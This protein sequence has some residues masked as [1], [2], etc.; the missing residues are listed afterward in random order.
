MIKKYFY[1][2][3][4]ICLLLISTS[5]KIY[6]QQ[7]GDRILA[8]VG[9][10]VIL[11][12]DLQKQ[13][14]VYMNQNNLT[15]YNERMIQ[16]IFN[17]LLAERLILA[18]AEQDSIYITDEEVKKQIDF[19]IKTLVEQLGSEKNVENYYGITINKIK[20]L[21]ADDIR[22]QLTIEKMKY[23][24]FPNGISVTR[25]EVTQFFSDYKDSLQEIPETYDLY[26]ISKAP[27]LSAEAKEIA[28]L[29]AQSILDSI[30]NGKDF[31]EM[32]RLYSEDS[33]SGANGGDLGSV[34]KGT[35]IKEFE[36]AAYL[37]KEDEIS[38]LV[39]TIFGYHI[40]KVNEKIGE[41][42]HASHILIRYP[43]LESADFDAIN[44]LKDTKSKTSGNLTSF[45]ESAV[46]YSDDKTS[47]A[48]SGYL[49]KLPITAFDS[50]EIDVL[51]VLEPG[52]ISEPVKVG[53]DRDYAYYI[54]YL[55]EKTPKHKAELENDYALIEKMAKNYKESKAFN[56]W[57]ED[58]K[59]TIYVEI[60]K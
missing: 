5:E 30:K 60:K 24:K 29:K 1:Y 13:L 12:S 45:K 36:D 37:L 6:S 50:L 22:N 25:A 34:K 15:D 27:V 49:G 43:R 10:Y 56:E 11:A 40:I 59:K 44:F 42:L 3:S 39:E 14:L 2:I 41:R 20:E 52:Q 18:K 46:I 55:K 32:A 33:A 19:R 28:R 7:E 4:A 35:F 48:D 47:A 57:M 9:N 16:N 26:Q 17:N 51:E 53:D 58:I 54:Y 23:R 38:N 21:W 31:S 8:I